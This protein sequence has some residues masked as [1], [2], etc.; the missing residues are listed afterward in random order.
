MRGIV[1]L[2]LGIGLTACSRCDR[3]YTGPTTTLAPASGDASSCGT[4][5]E[6]VNG[7]SH[8]TPSGRTFHVW[9]PSSYDG[10]R[11]LPVVFAVHGMGSDGRGFQRWFKMETFV[12]D[13]AIVVYPDSQK[14]LWDV[15]GDNDLAFFDAMIDGLGGAYCIDRSRVFAIGFSY[16]G[17]MVHHLGCKRT[18]RF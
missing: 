7:A 1:V 14:A 4:Q 16:G 3:G 5:K 18:E 2:A 11:A 6:A 12:D 10:T 15:H 9:T 17:K 8:R 13:A